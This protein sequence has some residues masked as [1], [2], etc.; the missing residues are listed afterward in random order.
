MNS[1]NLKR[2]M[3]SCS[4]L[5]IA[6]LA[7]STLPALGQ[8]DRPPYESP[9]PKFTFGTTLAEQEAQ[10]KNNPLLKRFSDSRKRLASD[11][12]RPLYHF[13][14]PEST[15]NDPNGLCFWNGKWHLFYQGYPPEDR[16]QH[17]GHAV[18]DD[19]IHWRDLPY[20]IYPSPERAVFSGATWVENNRVIAMYHG[21]AVGNMV[22]VS[23]D[24]L[25]LNW[26]KLT[27]GPVIPS[28][29]KTGFPAPYSVFDPC[30]WKKDDVYY[31]LSAGRLAMPPDGKPF[32]TTSLFRSKDLVTWEYVHEFVEGDR[33]TRIG[34]DYAC[35]YFVPIGDRYIMPFFSHMSGGQYL[36]GDYDKERD[37]FVVSNHGKFN[38]GAV[39][40][41][42]VHAPSATSDGKG[43]V[44]I[45]FNM[46]PGKPTG[47][48]NQIMSLPR[49]LTL[50][51]RDE[52]RQEP[53]GD[54]ESLRYNRKAVG[55][56]RL[57]A[58]KEVVIN[59]VKGDA[60]ELS[61]TIDL[62]ESQAIEVNVLR[63]PGKEEFTRIIFY[64]EKGF[65]DGL[66]YRSGEETARMPAD[67]VPL[68]TGRPAEPYKRGTRASVITIDASSASILPDVQVRPPESAPLVI[69]KD[70]LLNLRIFVDKSVVE[71]FANGK[72]CVAM[73]VYPG[74]NDSN[75][76]SIRSIG[77]EA[78]LQ[79][80][81]AWQM[82][83]IY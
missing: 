73:R 10:L 70:E 62:K 60:M 48:W 37:K 11:R 66:D 46:N 55:P 50:V 57:P 43:G 82:K 8:A 15:L 69:E 68:V 76:V 45:I 36:L 54:I 41:G 3:K 5:L 56:M 42:G 21:T 16:R 52:I 80:L 12:H 44:I 28:K 31:S 53:A 33:F 81:E 47:E 7:F 49:R 83:S 78:S 35:P 24:P 63:S 22:A 18:S 34:D 6:A 4:S 75:G 1:I 79:A 77:K 29:T 72:Q 74:R 9:V 71:V 65:S 14:S 17:W 59:G 19:L 58:N 67:L 51:G 39:G 23:D 38:F 2:M 26:K 25:L 40:P 32:G 20:A 61:L 13:V 30:I 64:R 27:D